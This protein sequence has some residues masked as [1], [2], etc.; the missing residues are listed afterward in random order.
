[1]ICRQGNAWNHKRVHGIYCLN[2]RR[3]GKQRLP[4]RRP[5]PLATPEALNQSE[6]SPVEGHRIHSKIYICNE[7]EF[8]SN[9]LPYPN[10]NLA[11]RR[12]TCPYTIS[13]VAGVGSK[14]FL[15]LVKSCFEEK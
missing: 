9:Y 2:F 14:N 10:K 4:G 5:A 8:D 1:M 3:K 15:K 7:F 13:S 6:V 11:N 12:G